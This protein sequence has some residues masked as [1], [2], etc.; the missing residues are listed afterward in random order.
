MTYPFLHSNNTHNSSAPILVLFIAGGKDQFDW[1]Q[2]LSDN[3]ILDPS[4]DRPR[5]TFEPNQNR[6]EC[7][8]GKDDFLTSVRVMNPPTMVVQRYQGDSVEHLEGIWR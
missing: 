8:L 5:Q 1:I 4:E 7:K 2:G 6:H 3:A